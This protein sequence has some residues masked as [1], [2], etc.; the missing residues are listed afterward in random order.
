V[1]YAF[2]LPLVLAAARPAGAGEAPAAAALT[3][4]LHW[5]LAGVDSVAVHDAFWD[6][7][8]VYTGSSGRRIGKREILE[9]MRAAPPPAPGDPATIYDAQ[10]IRIRQYGHTAVVAFRLIATTT[11]ESGDAGMTFFNTGTFVERDGDWKA[12]AWQATRIPPTADAAER[13]IRATQARLL[14]ALRGP[15]PGVL[16]VLLD[17]RFV[18]TRGGERLGKE[19]LLERV[20]SAQ[21]PSLPESAEVTVSVHG[22]AGIALG[23]WTRARAGEPASFTLALVNQGGVWRVVSL[24]SSAP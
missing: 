20:R 22:E 15:D 16:D 7:E 4:R 17:E 3:E 21:V 11:G 24:H 18:W 10:D 1:N 6:E 2:F 12:V 9:G 19:D 5:F 14:E 8:L 23:T 13:E